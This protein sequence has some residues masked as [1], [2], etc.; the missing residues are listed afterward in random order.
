MEYKISLGS[1]TYTFRDLRDLM[2]KATPQRSGDVLAGIAAATMEE[3]VAAKMCLADV[4]L[5]RFLE[6]AVIPYEKDEV[7][8]LIID[9]HDT[10]AFA[11]V[12]HLTVG[13]FRNW[14]LSDAASTE[15]LT[16]LAPG[17]TPE[18][19]AAVSKIMRNQDLILVASKCRVV[20]RF[21]NTLGLPAVWQ[22]ACSPT[23]PPT[24][25]EVLLPASLTD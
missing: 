18:M 19:A 22:C 23:T 3:R 2:A 8:R 12:A 20:T 4:P 1:T 6:E 24:T 9:S 5:K 16:L 17:I 14:L 15:A 11:P 25:S 10:R 7:T 21:R 13:D